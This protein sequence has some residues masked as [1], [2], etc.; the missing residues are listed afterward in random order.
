MS[1]CFNQAMGLYNVR[2]VKRL[3][4][5][6]LVF[7]ILYHPLAH[8]A[9]SKLFACVNLSIEDVAA[10]VDCGICPLAYFFKQNVILNLP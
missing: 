10:L 9:P 3:E 6:L 1:E 5:S 2:R 4:Y 7:E 8:L